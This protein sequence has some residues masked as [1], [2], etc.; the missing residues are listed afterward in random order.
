MSP[1]LC[2]PIISLFSMGHAQGLRKVQKIIQLI[3]L[4]FFYGNLLAYE[5][6]HDALSIDAK[7]DHSLAIGSSCP[8][9]AT[10]LR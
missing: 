4:E 1:N 6:E 7:N 2:L 9:L 5:S 8:V 3:W 10:V